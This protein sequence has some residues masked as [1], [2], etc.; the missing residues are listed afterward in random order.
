MQEQAGAGL[1]ERRSYSVAVYPRHGGKALLRIEDT[2][3]ARS[4]Q[5]AIDASH[6]LSYFWSH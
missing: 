3:R 2:D 1:G 6:A 5:E 4:A